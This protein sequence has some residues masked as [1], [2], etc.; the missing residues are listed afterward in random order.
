MC[1]RTCG[2]LAK[3][4]KRPAINTASLY[5]VVD[6][7]SGRRLIRGPGDEAAFWPPPG[8]TCYRLTAAGR[9]EVNDWLTELISTPVGS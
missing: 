3:H 9:I 5:V 2:K 4:D 8:G 6:R 7:S 1:P